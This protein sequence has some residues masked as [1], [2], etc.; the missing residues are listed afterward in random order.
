MCITCWG[1]TYVLNPRF[2]P[3]R[4]LFIVLSG[5]GLVLTQTCFIYPGQQTRQYMHSRF[6]ESDNCYAYYATLSFSF[7]VVLS[8]P[9]NALNNI[10]S[11]DVFYRT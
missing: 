9:Q 6:G 5:F 11:A 4:N 10:P 2:N 1:R 7:S 3:A 8:E